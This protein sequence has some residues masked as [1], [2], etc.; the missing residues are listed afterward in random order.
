MEMDCIGDCELNA[1]IGWYNNN[2]THMFISCYV[3]YI[4]GYTMLYYSSRDAVLSFLCAVVIAIANFN[5]T[6]NAV[7]KKYPDIILLRSLNSTFD[8]FVSKKTI[9]FNWKMYW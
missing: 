4:D 5:P 2:A 9:T 3:Q 1:L 8:T 7:H 6:K